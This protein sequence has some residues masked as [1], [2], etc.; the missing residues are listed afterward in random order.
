M[1]R[2]PCAAARRRQHALVVLLSL[3]WGFNQ[4]AIKLAINDI[5]R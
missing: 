4:P 2:Q 3:T 1:S 5:R